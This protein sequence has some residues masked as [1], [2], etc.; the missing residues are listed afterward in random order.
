[1]R[2]FRVLCLTDHLK[3]SKENSLY[4]LASEMVRH[5]RCEEMMVASR[6]NPSNESFFS[7]LNFDKI[8]VSEVDFDFSF[9]SGKTKLM[10]STRE[11]SPK[12]FDI[13]FLR[14]PR[15]VSDKFLLKLEYT[16]SNKCIINKPSGII[17][18]SSK[19]VLLNFQD[20]CPPIRLCQ[21]IDEIIEFSKECDIV[22]KPLREYGGKGLLKITGDILNDGIADF[23]TRPYLLRIEEDI[24]KDGYLAMKYLKNV[25]QGDKRLIVVGGEILAAS[26][27]L[28]SEDSWLCNVAAGGTSVAAL[29]DDREREII[30]KI[31]PFLSQ[32][33]IL[34]CG[35]DTLVDD[36]GHRTLSE[37]NALSIGG[38]P[39]A[40]KQTGRPIINRTIN[41]MMDY[42]DDHFNQ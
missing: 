10:E 12:D 22:L 20:V 16:F 31:S 8:F 2:K 27:R 24:E 30:N 1:M 25:N 3:H 36:D 40:E 32:R 7:D 9:E 38:F 19:A 21:S 15:P 34:I 37:I 28:P 23:S 26:L 18:C 17:E 29:P 6:S 33:G 13:I 4:A 5:D 14:L 41:K 42:A 11:V 39:Q 35:V